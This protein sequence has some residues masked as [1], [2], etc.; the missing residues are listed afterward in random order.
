MTVKVTQFV[1]TCHLTWF[2]RWNAFCRKRV[3]L[4]FFPSR[5]QFIGETKGSFCPTS[6]CL[7]IMLSHKGYNFID[8]H[9]ASIKFA[10]MIKHDET[11]HPMEVKVTYKVKVTQ[12]GSNIWHATYLFLN[13]NVW[14][15]FPKTNYHYRGIHTLYLYS[16]IMHYYIKQKVKKEIRFHTLYLYT[17]KCAYIC[18]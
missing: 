5:L 10:T 1:I 2:D 13:N 16:V 7:E 12:Y 14:P 6:V 9:Y 17:A 11:R 8:M 18:F 15:L 3:C 4:C